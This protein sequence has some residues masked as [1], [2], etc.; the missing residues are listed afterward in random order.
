MIPLLPSLTTSLASLTGPDSSP[1]SSGAAARGSATMPE[2]SFSQVFEQVAKNGIDALK[3]GEASAIAGINGQATI[4]RVV[5]DV[6]AA[7]RTLQTVVALRD[8][9]V[10]AYQEVSRMTI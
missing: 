1:L 10:A 4:Q 3:G 7:D 6:M 9:A 8:K 2:P 5:E